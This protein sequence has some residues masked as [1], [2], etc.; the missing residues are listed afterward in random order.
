[1]EV[2]PSLCTSK[3]NVKLIRSIYTLE[4]L[5]NDVITETVSFPQLSFLPVS[6]EVSLNWEKAH[7]KF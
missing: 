5:L 7:I 6:L 4:T 1:M 3:P 2:S